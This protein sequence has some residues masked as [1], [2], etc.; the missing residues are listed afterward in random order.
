M[1]GWLT[2]VGI[3]KFAGGHVLRDAR[4]FF[5]ALILVEAFVGGVSSLVRTI[6]QGAIPAF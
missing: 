5:I 2:K 4:F 6:S 1:R 3:M